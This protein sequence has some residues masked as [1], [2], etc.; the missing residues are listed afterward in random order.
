MNSA[1]TAPLDP[2]WLDGALTE[3]AACHQPAA[4]RRGEAASICAHCGASPV[5]PPPVPSD[6]FGGASSLQLVDLRRAPAGL[7]D[8]GERPGAPRL[9]ALRRAWEETKA[10]IAGAHVAADELRAT[11]LAATLARIYGV[12][13]DPVR[14]RAVLEAALERLDVP[15]YRALTQAR[16]ARAAAFAGHLELAD[17]WLAE[18]PFPTGIVAID[19]DVTVARALLLLKQGDHA[20]VLALL[21]EDDDSPAFAG[22]VRPFADLVRIDALERSG[23]AYAAYVLYRKAIRESGAIPL[24]GL[25][26]YYRLGVKTRRWIVTTGLL[27]LVVILALLVVA[28]RLATD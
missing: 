8:L 18:A 21:G 5:S 19:G 14:E 17:R 2:G 7:E 12:T 13:G 10:T 9:P 25:V 23:R 28:W 20:A 24:Q 15:A 22:L 27:A 16:L 26:M 11:W 1:A 3:C 4:I 6:D